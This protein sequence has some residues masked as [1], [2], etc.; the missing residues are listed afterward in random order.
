MADQVPVANTLWDFRGALMVVGAFKKHFEGFAQ[1][2]DL[3]SY[4]SPKGHPYLP[5]VQTGLV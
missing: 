2:L 5:S 4:P 3:P 1:Q